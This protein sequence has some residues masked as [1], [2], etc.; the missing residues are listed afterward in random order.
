MTIAIQS[1]ETDYVCVTDFVFTGRWRVNSVVY[2]SHQ[3]D[4]KFEVTVKLPSFIPFLKK[5][6]TFWADDDRFV[7]IN[8]CNEKN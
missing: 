8:D 6:I 7:E 2:E 5:K 1:S 4:V 3:P